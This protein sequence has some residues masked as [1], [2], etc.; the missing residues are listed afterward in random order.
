MI[1]SRHLTS[2]VRQI[3]TGSHPWGSL[4]EQIA[5]GPFCLDVAST[6][7][8]REGVELALRPRAFH[9]LK[10]LLHNSGRHVDY[11][12]ML[13]EAWEGN[14]VSRHTVA[15][16][17]GEVK[18]VLRECGSWISYRPKLGYRL[19]VPQSDDLIRKAWHFWKRLTRDGFEKA[20]DCF[21]RA[22]LE[23][24]ADPRAFEGSSLTYLTLGAAGMK[25]PRDMSRAFLE[26]HNQAVALAGLTPELRSD[27]GHGLHIFEHRMDE[28]EAE[29]QQSLR[30]RQW[31]TTY[32]RLTMLYIADGRLDAAVEILNEAYGVDALDPMLPVME[33]NVRFCRREFERAVACGRKALELHP[34]V[35]F[36][37]AFYA[38]ALEYAGHAREALEQYRRASL[39]SPDLPWVRALEGACMA[40]NGR[41]PQA[42]RILDELQ[43]LRA[44]EYVDAY[45]LALLLDAIGD[46][47]EAFREL[48]RAREENSSAMHILHIDPKMDSLRQ[49]PRWE[50]LRQQLPG[51]AAL[52][53]TVGSAA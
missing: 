6:R 26:A 3:L 42:L 17:I 50:R 20:L 53:Q 35:Q 12:Q 44:A 43:R 13:R 34:Y 27:R 51:G 37:P 28:A 2:N 47:D 36:A 30:E 16:T 23:D 49:D 38:Q 41:R 29:L 11:E 21:Q 10:T 24:S 9:A 15:V 8:T 25:P 5:F 33:I 4:V 39:L 46:R 1:Y 14:T 18:K 52:P 7:L 19:E 40:R 45:Y 48:E 32:L 22:A 31:V